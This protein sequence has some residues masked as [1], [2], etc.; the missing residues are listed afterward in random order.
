MKTGDWVRFQLGGKLVTG[1][2]EYVKPRASWER[3]DTLV[4]DVG[5]AKVEAVL[6]V[7]SREES[8]R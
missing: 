3:C 7:R 2:V 4:T 1:V 5:E 6:E 8:Q